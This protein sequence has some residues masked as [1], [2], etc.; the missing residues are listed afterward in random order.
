M[1]I[2]SIRVLGNAAPA[3][4]VEWLTRLSDIPNETFSLGYADSDAVGPAPGG[5]AGAA[6]AHLPRLRHRPE[7]LHPVAHLRRRAVDRDSDAGPTAGTTPSPSPTAAPGPAIPDL[8]TLLAWDYTL[9]GISWPGDKT[10]RRADLAP[11]AAAGLTTTIVSGSNTNAA[12]LTTTPNAP[13]ASGNDHLRLLRPAT[14]RGAPPGDHRAERRGLELRHVEGER[15]AGADQSGVG[16][17]PQAARRP[18]SLVA[19]ERNPAG[20]HAQLAVLVARGRL[21]PPSRRS[22]RRRRPPASTWS[23]LPSRRSASR[24]SAPWFR[25]RDRS[26]SSPRSST[27]RRG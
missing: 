5:P 20:A 27:T 21:P 1:I 19:V 2:A 12:D 17:R 11:L 13:V 15:A 16:R 9:T 10:V 26:D 22:R 23:T 6:P 24:T 14:Q 4:A 3:S 25:M 8:K 18:G 7:E